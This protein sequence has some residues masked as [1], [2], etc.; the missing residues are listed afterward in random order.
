MFEFAEFNKP[1]L[2]D[3]DLYRF[4]NRKEKSNKQLNK[5]V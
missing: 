1:L 3:V 5:T 4:K 2:P